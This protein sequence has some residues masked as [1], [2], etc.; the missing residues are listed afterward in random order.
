MKTYF[1]NTTV[2]AVFRFQRAYGLVKSIFF[3][4]EQPEASLF[5]RRT[6][7]SFCPPS[8]LDDLQVDHLFSELSTLDRSLQLF[9][10][11]KENSPYSWKIKSRSRGAGVSELG[12]KVML[13]EGLPPWDFS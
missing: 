4:C 8:I 2:I 10:F 9:L 6:L 12:D 5:D 11:K 7:F 3:P 1:S 13:R